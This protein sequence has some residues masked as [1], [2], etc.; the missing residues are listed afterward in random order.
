MKKVLIT[1]ASK[2]IGRATAELLFNHGF[3]V[4]GTSR[5]SERI[6]NAPEGVVYEALDM[7]SRESID[8]LV[9]KTGPIDILINNAGQSQIG[10]AEEVP[11][12]EIGNLFNMNL[13]HVIYLTQCILKEMRKK[14]KGLIINVGSMQSRIPLPY[15]SIYAATKCG[16]EGF[17]KSLR[18]E[19]FQLGI[20][21]VVL[22]PGFI[23]TSIIQNQYI[24]EDSEYRQNYSNIKK[25][26]D[27]NFQNGASPQEVARA[28]HK[29]ISMKNPPPVFVTGGNAPQLNFLCRILPE[30]IFEMIYR[31]KLGL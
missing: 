13:L 30:K 5:D 8:K 6:K 12:P 3:Y 26:R 17:S 4:I 9:N 11:F 16:M 31:K 28:I 29:L 1:G 19:V 27:T 10:P 14:R 24:V 25:F 23:K 7:N 2:G 18:N 20:D 21:V 22:L 15:C